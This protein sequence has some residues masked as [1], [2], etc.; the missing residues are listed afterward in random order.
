MQFVVNSNNTKT[1]ETIT[2]DDDDELHILDRI[3]IHHIISE[4]AAVDVAALEAATTD[5]AF[6]WDANRIPA[7]TMGVG[8]VQEPKV[9]WLLLFKIGLECKEDAVDAKFDGIIVDEDDEDDTNIDEFEE[10]RPVDGVFVAEEE[11]EFDE[12][13]DDDDEVLL[14][15]VC[16]GMSIVCVSL[17]KMRRKRFFC[18]VSCT[19]GLQYTEGDVNPAS[20]AGADPVRGGDCILMAW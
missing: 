7:A 15:A 17:P 2:N 3:E 4:V 12:N 20:S 8:N 10:R 18:G 13:D 14:L 1:K 9:W 5:A 19:T 11:A 6:C 16:G